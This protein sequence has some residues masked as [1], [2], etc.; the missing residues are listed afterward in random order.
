MQR[1]PWPIRTNKT[2]TPN[3]ADLKGGGCDVRIDRQCKYNSGNSGYRASPGR[4]NAKNLHAITLALVV[5]S[6]VGDRFAFLLPIV[7]IH[8]RR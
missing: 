1:I 2:L 7:N 4:I 3:G 8:V 5:P 6:R